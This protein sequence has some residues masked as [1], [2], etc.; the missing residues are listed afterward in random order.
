MLG[1][2]L[3]LVDNSGKDGLVDVHVDEAVLNQG[4]DNEEERGEGRGHERGREEV[5]AHLC[6]SPLRPGVEVSDEGLAASTASA[7]PWKKENN[8]RQ[9]SKRGSATGRSSGIKGATK[10]RGVLEPVLEVARELEVVAQ[11]ARVAHV[12][13]VVVARG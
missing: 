13:V 12:V 2:V 10:R 6:R 9:T 8:G 3:G 5:L 1:R 11:V 4:A 7:T